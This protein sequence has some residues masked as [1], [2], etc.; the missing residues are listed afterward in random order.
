[1]GW[2]LSNWLELRSRDEDIRASC[3]F[4]SLPCEEER[5][6]VLALPGQTDDQGNIAL[7]SGIGTAVGLGGLITGIYFLASGEDPDSFKLRIDDSE[8]GFMPVFESGPQQSTIGI[9]GTF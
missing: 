6:A 5:K 3:D 8:F 4:E 1:M 7:L 9:R 2:S